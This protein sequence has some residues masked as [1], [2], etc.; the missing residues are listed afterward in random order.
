VINKTPA[1]AKRKEKQKF[2]YAMYK[3]IH[4]DPEPIYCVLNSK[5]QC[6]RE[7]NLHRCNHTVCPLTKRFSLEDG[8]CYPLSL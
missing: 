4:E 7:S 6:L 2:T 1:N 5:H 3:A 8:I